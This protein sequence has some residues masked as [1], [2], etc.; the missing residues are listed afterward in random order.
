MN[1]SERTLQRYLKRENIQSRQVLEEIRIDWSNLNQ[2]PTAEGA[3]RAG[4]N[5]QPYFLQDEQGKRYP[6]TPTIARKL[7]KQGYGVW[8]M[9]RSVNMYWY[10]GEPMPKIQIQPEAKS[11]PIELGFTKPDYSVLDEMIIPIQTM[12]IQSDVPMNKITPFPQNTVKPEPQKHSDQQP[13]RS[14]RFY[15]KPLPDAKDEWLAQKVYL[16]TG[17]LQEVEARQ[18]IDNY[19]R[20]AVGQALG[21]MEYMCEKGDL[22]NPAGFMKVVSRVCWR[23]INGFDV[24]RPEYQSPKKRKPRKTVY[25]PQNDPIWQSKSYRQW[26][27]AFGEAPIDIWEIPCLDNEIEF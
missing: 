15:K 22:Q 7:L 26:R 12:P 14:A 6:P 3:R 11:E 17:N 5:M 1:V 18:L 13:K 10:G 20:K 25:N 19:G 8:L 16:S 27:L 2:I 9:K 4:F 21:R 24:P 23:S